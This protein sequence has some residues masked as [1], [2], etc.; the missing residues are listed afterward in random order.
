M[1]ERKG[2]RV[3][4]WFDLSKDSNPFELFNQVGANL[5]LKNVVEEIPEQPAVIVEALEGDFLSNIVS[6][7][8]HWEERREDRKWKKEKE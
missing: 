2:K 1:R 8:S 5:A 3:K 4:G 7:V 6:D